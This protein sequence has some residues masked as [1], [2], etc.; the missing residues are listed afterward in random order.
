MYG[1]E[2]TWCPY[3]TVYVLTKSLSIFV[4]EEAKCRKMRAV[5]GRDI[6]VVS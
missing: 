5:K 2:V 1:S 4:T 3:V 6:E